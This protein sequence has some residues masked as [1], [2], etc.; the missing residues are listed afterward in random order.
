MFLCKQRKPGFP[1]EKWW[2][3]LTEQRRPILPFETITVYTGLLNRNKWNGRNKI[4]RRKYNHLCRRCSIID[5][6]APS[7]RQDGSRC[8]VSLLLQRHRSTE[9]DDCDSDFVCSCCCHLFPGAHQVWTGPVDANFIH[10]QRHHLFWRVGG[11]GLLAGN[12]H[13]CSVFAYYGV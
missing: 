8:F 4:E 1:G 11:H 12:R 10:F 6:W 5:D 3:R 7:R 2:T 9:D 13:R